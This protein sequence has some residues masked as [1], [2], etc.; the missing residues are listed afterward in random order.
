M[1]LGPQLI[2]LLN[3][4]Y[5]PSST[6]ETV[7]NKYDLTFKTDDQGRPILAF[8]GNKGPNGII[9]GERFA[10]RIVTDQTGQVIKDHWDNKGKS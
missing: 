8:I 3:K 2:T 5:E 6:I 9:K 4:R 1:K 7:F 10:R